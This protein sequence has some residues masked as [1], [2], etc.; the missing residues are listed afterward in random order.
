V[1]GQAEASFWVGATEGL[2]VVGLLVGA[3]SDGL[4]VVGA[5]L[6]VEFDG[7]SVVGSL[8]GAVG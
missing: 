4:A 2:N 7:V 5:A 6:V 8:V 1:V 3:S